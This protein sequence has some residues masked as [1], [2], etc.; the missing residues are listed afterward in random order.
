[1]SD[2]AKDDEK[3]KE[4]EE[5]EIEARSAPPGSVVYEAI[6]REGDH[7]LGRHSSALAWSGLAAGLSMG[8]SFLAEALLRTYLPERSWTPAVS[9]FGYSIGFLI[10]ILGRQQLFTKNTLTVILPLLSNREPQRFADVARLWVVVLIS[11]LVGALIF[12]CLLAHTPAFDATA[13]AL[14]SRMSG[15]ELM[16]D[17]FFA[18]LLRG[19][20]AGW[21]IALMIWLLPFAESAHVLVITI[22]AYVV[23]LGR[24]PHIIAGSVGTFYSLVTGGSGVGEALM[25]FF[26]PT[27]LGNIIGGVAIVAALAHAEFIGESGGDGGD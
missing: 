10:V 27:L 13:K 9:K 14:F 1:M 16:H 7:E 19:F 23:G 21:I 22:L 24:F 26:L 18:V 20:F 5:D 2:P 17:G 15:E 11:N 25:D 3:K 12:A 6:Y 8:F 4:R